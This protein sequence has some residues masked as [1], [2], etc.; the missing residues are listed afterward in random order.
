MPPFL[1]AA[2]AAAQILTNQTCDDGFLKSLGEY[3]R[4]D[5]SALREIADEVPVAPVLVPSYSSAGQTVCASLKGQLGCCSNATLAAVFKAY[6]R[7]SEAIDSA[8]AAAGFRDYVTR[9]L[10]MLVPTAKLLC[11]QDAGCKERVVQAV[12]DN[13][14]KLNS[15]ISA[16]QDD[17]RTCISGLKAYAMGAAC[18]ACSPAA[19]SFLV[20]SSGGGSRRRG[21][22]I[23]QATC[24]RVADGCTPLL[25]SS[26]DVLAVRPSRPPEPACSS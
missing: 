15:S 16:M 18:F 2:L 7:A 13:S 24:D 22:R 12:G 8:N 4:G 20:N 14:P 10:A 5:W 6:S 3:S 9:L 23:A 21:I 19:S 25:S 26:N 1:L 11:G 17:L